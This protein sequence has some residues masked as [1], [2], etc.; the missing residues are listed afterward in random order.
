[1]TTTELG[2]VNVERGC[3]CGR[4]RPSQNRSYAAYGR[5]FKVARAG[6]SRMYWAVGKARGARAMFLDKL[7]CRATRSE[8]QEALDAWAARRGLKPL[9]G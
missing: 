9:E 2:T 4:K 8:M 1:M 7:G 6:R 5:V 3:G